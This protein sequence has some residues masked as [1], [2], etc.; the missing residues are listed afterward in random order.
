MLHIMLPNLQLI[1]FFVCSFI[2]SFKKVLL[3]RL[4]MSSI[5]VYYI[6]IIPNILNKVVDCMEFRIVEGYL[7]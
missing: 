4:A 3:R 2:K 6:T 1:L 7:I 5:I